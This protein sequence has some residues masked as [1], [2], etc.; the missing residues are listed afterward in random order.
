MK[1]MR[2]YDVEETKKEEQKWSIS[3]EAYFS[4]CVKPSK[5]LD[6]DKT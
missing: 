5:I 2:A 3:S 6:H 4:F 1:E